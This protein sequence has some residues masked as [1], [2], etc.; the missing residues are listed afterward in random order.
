MSKFTHWVP[1]LILL[2]L[3]AIVGTGCTAK[4]K[5]SYHQKRA[6][7]YYATGEFD[8]AEIE[9]K[10]V[11]RNDPQNARAWSRLG[12]I[13]FD[14]GRLGEAAQILHRAL[15]LATNDLQVRLKLG[16][17]YLGTGKLNEALDEASFVLNR[18]PRDAQAPILLA[19]AATST[20]EINETRLRLQTMSQTGKTAPLEVAMGTL[21]FRQHDLKAAEACFQ[22][23][24]RL[25][26]KFSD[27]YSA[28][29]NVYLAQKDVKQAELAFKTAMELAPP[30]S[31]KTLLYAQFKILTG[32]PDSGKSLLQN[33]VKK[34]PDYLPAWIA[35]AQLAGASKDYD[36]G[37][38]LLG[39]VLS[40]DPR[41]SEALLLKG[42]LELEQ[43]AT[44]QAIK[45]F[46]AMVMIFPNMPS[47]YY[48][49]AKAQA[50]AG[51]FDKATGNVNQALKLNPHYTDATLLLAEI[52]V[53]NRNY[54]P[55]MTSLQ[56]LIHQQ[57]QSVSARFLL[58][59]AYSDQN[60]LD[61]AIQIYRELEKA[62]PTDS[63]VPL[64]IG[65]ALFQQNKN[66]EARAEYE[67]ALK[68]APDYLPA[69]QQ[70]VNLD[71]LE[72]QYDSAQQRVQQQIRQNPKAVPLQLMLARVLTARGDTDQ[73]ESVL[74]QTITLAPDSQQAFMMLAKL[75][76]A[77]NE[78]QNALDNLSAVLAKNPEAGD[79]LLLMGLTYNAEKKYPDARDAYEKLLAVTPNNVMV[80]NN[81]AYLYAHNLGQL[82]KG[83]QLARHALDL[84]PTNSSIADTLGWI[85]YQQGQYSSALNLLRESAGKQDA[86][87]EVQF[88]LGM[89]YYMLGD[90]AN[91]RTTFQR[92][93]QLDPSFPEHNE[94]NDCL[95]VLAV[96]PK[97]AGAD[98]RAWLEKRVAGQPKDFVAQLRLAEIYQREGTPDMAIA[99]YEAVLQ[100]SP[101]NVPALVNLAGLY[102]AHDPQKAFNLAKMAYKLAPNNP[103][104][105]HT[106][107]HLAFLTGD[108]AWSVSLLQL[109]DRVQPQNPDILY[110]L[111]EAFYSVGRVS[112]A[113]TAMQSALQAGATF[114][115]AAAAR[116]LLVITDLTDKPAQALAAQSQV[117]DILKAEPDYVPALMVKAAIAM[118]KPDLVTAQQTYEAVLDNYPG[119]TPA[120][121]H[122]VLLYA[123][124]GKNDGKAYPLAVKARQAFPDSPEVAK[125]LGLIVYRQG[126]YARA[127]S[128]LEESASQLNRGDPELMYYLGMASYQLKHNAQCKI[129]LQKALDLNLSGT[130]AVD[131][132]RILA[133]L[134]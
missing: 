108:Y 16:T 36:G 133:E 2:L 43:G 3:L 132:K 78:N 91:A 77:A 76:A 11:L 102:S 5:A 101:Q 110:D 12:F 105:T 56:Q 42:R 70:E 89:T 41:N 19:E 24:A 37:V 4:L 49:L 44:A 13:Y 116:R 107:G 10:N 123:E 69:L 128:L 26:P 14:E 20:N 61:N 88:H 122:L 72:K 25:D 52:Q 64:L 90:E 84:E 21:F 99:A 22:T 67:Q 112:D 7:Q 80:L 40:R 103:L 124:D 74:K 121:K 83:Y 71:L 134:K 15:Q 125:A 104:V 93:L 81:L 23:A 45:D 109:T 118:Q 86:K 46:E 58:A 96:D 92:A 35:L 1:L 34:T 75:Y 113:R 73:A 30:R 57:S 106:L 50:A 38:T 131:A 114:S 97:T 117:E 126:D 98:T 17:I 100:A 115:Q 87:P 53:Y 120:E 60:R 9:Y 28:L 85:L 33:L 59:R 27:A 119:F 18:D 8:Q 32:D 51:D 82:D 63:Q 6:D 79:A 29:G 55:A 130:Q 54:E 66:A 111:G 95:T 31:G 62:L 39:N 129:A 65:N 94:C 68:L 48:Q 47:A 127:A